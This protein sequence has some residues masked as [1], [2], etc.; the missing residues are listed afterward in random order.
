MYKT[1]IFALQFIIFLFSP[2]A[3]A[4]KS[5]CKSDEKIIFSC[6][7]GHA[8]TVSVCASQSLA[9]GGYIQYRFGRKNKIDLSIPSTIKASD[10]SI[11]GNSGGNRSGGSFIRFRIGVYSYVVLSLY[12]M[13]SDPETGCNG[14]SCEQVGVLVEKSGNVISRLSC[15]G[16]YGAEITDFPNGYLDRFGIPRAQAYWPE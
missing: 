5:L 3:L 13:P 6:P 16:T 10:V 12:S 11:D 4:S 9:K 2:A 8:K 7:V 1:F 15:K 14:G